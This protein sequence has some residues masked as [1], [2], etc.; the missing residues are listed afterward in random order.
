LWLSGA[1]VAYLGRG[2]RLVYFGLAVFWH[3]M[4]AHSKMNEDDGGDEEE[5]QEQEEKK[6][7]RMKGREQKVARVLCFTASI[8]LRYL[9]FV[10]SSRSDAVVFAGAAGVYAWLVDVGQVL[11]ARMLRFR[12]LLALLRPRPR[13]LLC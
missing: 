12:G 6:G 8:F 13:A 9:F 5:E 11:L 4:L 7:H 1:R 10:G 3:V 2:D